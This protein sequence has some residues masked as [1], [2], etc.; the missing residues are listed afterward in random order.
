MARGMHKGPRNKS[1]I[2]KP[3]SNG[4]PIVGRKSCVDRRSKTLVIN[5]SDEGRG[6]RMHQPGSYKK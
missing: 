5:S 2:G 6:L 4:D 3:G 1:N